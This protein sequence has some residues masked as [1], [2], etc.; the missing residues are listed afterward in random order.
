MIA[1][2]M[3][4]RAAAAPWS[5]AGSGRA[6]A[7]A[8]AITGG[9]RWWRRWT[10]AAASAVA[11]IFRRSVFSSRV[12]AL[13]CGVLIILGCDEPILGRKRAIDRDHG[14]QDRTRRSV[15]IMLAAM[16]AGNHRHLHCHGQAINVR[17]PI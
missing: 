14:L 9:R 13:A 7:T 6:A 2:A 3:A 5:R 8:A 11:A 1:G 4:A 12:S 17:I 16:A 10:A 15:H